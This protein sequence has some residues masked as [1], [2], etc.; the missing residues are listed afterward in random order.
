M[1][2][3]VKKECADHYK[4]WI[5]DEHT[6]QLIDFEANDSGIYI[7]KSRS[8]EENDTTFTYVL[9]G[10]ISIFQFHNCL[11]LKFIYFNLELKYSGTL[12][13]KTFYLGTLLQ[14]QDY[15]N[16]VLDPINEMFDRSKQD[17]FI[18]FKKYFKFSFRL[19]TLWDNWGPCIINSSGP[20]VRNKIGKCFLYPLFNNASSVSMSFSIFKHL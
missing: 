5:D 9:D 2:E 16:T 10:K 3:I 17:P 14:W 6:L 4:I 1:K 11:I 12:P 7:C 15:K 18:K 8:T 20:M 19:F 13:E